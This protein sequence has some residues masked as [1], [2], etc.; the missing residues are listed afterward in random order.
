[1]CAQTDPD[2]F[3]PE[4]RGA[5]SREAL[6]VC[7]KCEVAEECLAYAL[8]YE[9]HGVW[10]GKSENQRKKLRK[11]LGIRLIAPDTIPHGTAAGA[12]AH[13]RKKETPCAPCRQAQAVRERERLKGTG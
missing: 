4:K 8:L 2:I 9:K 5:N 7:R 3:Y 11:K 13:Q 12:R 1:M 6:A 10:G